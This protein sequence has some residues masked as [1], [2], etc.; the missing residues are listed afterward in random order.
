MY[1]DKNLINRRNVKA[2]VHQ[3]YTQCKEF[4]ILEFETRVVAAFQVLGMSSLNGTPVNIKIP[5]SAQEN[6]RQSVFRM[7][8]SH[9]VSQGVLDTFICGNS[10]TSSLIS[11]ILDE[12]KIQHI[13]SSRRPI[14][15]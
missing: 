9:K 12:D 3:A 8:Y 1:S 6:K 11:S 2:D 13:Q 5:Q 15:V 14:H 7:L 4:F 10:Q